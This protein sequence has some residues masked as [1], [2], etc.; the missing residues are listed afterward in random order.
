MKQY[1]V[2]YDHKEEHFN[3]LSKAHEFAESQGLLG[4]DIVIYDNHRDK[5]RKIIAEDK[6]VRT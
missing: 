6:G 4:H 3:D 2:E 1:T 5:G